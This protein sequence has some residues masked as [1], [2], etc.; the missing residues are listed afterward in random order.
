MLD[1]P[2]V[3]PDAIRR[4][5]PDILVGE[6]EPLRSD[7]VGSRQAGQHGHVNELLL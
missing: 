5:E 6:S 3:K 1:E 4:A 7:G 2:R